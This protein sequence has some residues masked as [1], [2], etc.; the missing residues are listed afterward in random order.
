MK[1]YKIINQLST[2]FNVIT[3]NVSW[4]AMTSTPIGLFTMC[5]K[6]LCK[7]NI[8][9]NIKRQKYFHPNGKL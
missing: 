1:K 9:S 3:Y 5:K 7:N 4:E 8:L 2:S 6:G